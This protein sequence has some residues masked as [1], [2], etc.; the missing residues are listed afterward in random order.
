MTRWPRVSGGQEP[1]VPSHLHSHLPVGHS[2]LSSPQGP[3]RHPDKPGHPGHP[4]T[5]ESCPPQLYSRPWETPTHRRAQGPPVALAAHRALVG[6]QVRALCPRSPPS[7][8][9]PARP[10]LGLSLRGPCSAACLPALSFPPM[11]RTH[12]TLSS[13]AGLE[14]GRFGCT[15][16]PGPISHGHP[17]PNNTLPHTPL[18][19]GLWTSGSAFPAPYLAFRAAPQEC[20][21]GQGEPLRALA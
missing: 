13:S 4:R 20:R 10:A 21:E 19:G 14:G 11:P 7:G 1:R 15:Q 9:S 6:G 16:G 5:L 3:L 12:P 8:A 2:C 18:P 17:T